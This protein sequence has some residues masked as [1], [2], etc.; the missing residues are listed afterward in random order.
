MTKEE[1]KY[2]L[3]ITKDQLKLITKA[4]D[5]W[6]RLHIGQCGDLIDEL[7]YDGHPKNTIFSDEKEL[8]YYI[9]RQYA[10]RKVMQLALEFAMPD[11]IGQHDAD[12]KLVFDIVRFIKHQLYLDDGGTP[13][14]T[15]VWSRDPDMLF[16]GDT[17]PQ[18]KQFDPNEYQLTESDLKKLEH[19]RVYNKGVE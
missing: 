18:I 2:Q 16:S 8:N 10:A 5:Q 1:P 9:N 14:S 12:S 17:E 4:L 11:T 13:N 6:G 7:S 19:S 15:S 3:I